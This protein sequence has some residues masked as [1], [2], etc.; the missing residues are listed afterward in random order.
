MKTVFLNVY[1]KSAVTCISW[2]SG[3][4]IYIGLNKLVFDLWRI[5]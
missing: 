2:T 3:I 5:S 4:V 1:D